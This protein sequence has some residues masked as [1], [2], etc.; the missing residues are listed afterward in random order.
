MIKQ[1]YTKKKYK[2]AVNL[3]MTLDYRF[4]DHDETTMK[5]LTEL[6]ATG[7]LENINASLNCM[8]T[9]ENKLSEC[10]LD[11]EM[12]TSSVIEMCMGLFIQNKSNEYRQ[13]YVRN[14]EAQDLAVKSKLEK[15]EK[16]PT[17]EKIRKLRAE[18]SNP[19]FKLKLISAAIYKNLSSL[20]T[21]IGPSAILTLVWDNNKILNTLLKQLQ[22]CGTT[23][24]GT[25]TPSLSESSGKTLEMGTELKEREVVVS[26]ILELLEQIKK[27]IAGTANNNNN[28]HVNAIDQALTDF[29]TL[30]TEI[31]SPTQNNNNEN[32]S[33]DADE[34]LEQNF[35][36]I[37]IG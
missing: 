33:S 13:E 25:T 2:E 22:I 3:L 29:K 21:D 32:N 30:Q 17:G 24:T 20:R 18:Y 23:Y 36:T 8:S 10:R 16:N 11:Y 1:L 19:F 12:K 34:E 6:A 14:K 4:T 9:I 31:I 26:K 5:C 35:S 28:V 15:L 27:T 7:V 37:Q